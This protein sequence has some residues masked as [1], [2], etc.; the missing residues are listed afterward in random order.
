MITEKVVIKI[1]D[2]V[3]DSAYGMSGLIVELNPKWVDSESGEN[4]TW[5]FGVLYEDGQ[6]GYADSCE[7]TLVE[8]KK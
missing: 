3:Q 5:Q 6:L 2:V 7:L 8:I 1:G 4:H